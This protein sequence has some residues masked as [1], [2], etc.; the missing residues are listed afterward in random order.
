MKLTK[1]EELAYGQFV[2]NPTQAY[3]AYYELAKKLHGTRGVSSGSRN[4]DFYM[5][6]TRGPWVRTWLAA[7]AQGKSTVLRVI[8]FNEANRLVMENATD[9]FY[10]AHISYEEAVDAQEIYYQRDRHYSNE[11]FWRGK[12]DFKLGADFEYLGEK[13]QPVLS[14]LAT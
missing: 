3:Q 10:V 13:L 14:I 5:I 6:P 4:L 7:P 2:H 11:D 8:A 9:K 1:D 12:V